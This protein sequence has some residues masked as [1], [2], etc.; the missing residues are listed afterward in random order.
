MLAKLLRYCESKLSSEA[1]KDLRWYDAG[2]PKR[3]SVQSFFHAYARALLV[4]GI[5]AT[6][7]DTW[8]KNHRFFEIFTLENCK[9]RTATALLRA[10]G[11][12][13]NNVRGSKLTAIHALGHE[14]ASLTPRQAAD[15]YFSGTLLSSELGERHVPEL[16]KLRFVAPTNARF[17]LLNMGAEELL[18]CDTWLTAFMHYFRCDVQALKQAGRK[19][20]WKLGRVDRVLWWYCKQEIRSSKNLPAHFRKLGFV[21]ITGPSPRKR[22]MGTSNC[23]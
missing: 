4:S 19:L 16:D 10:V 1:K 21:P 20:G 8:A 5:G 6:A 18:K 2:R 7:A 14:L 23:Q 15:R 9:R 11:Q 22:A 17:I 12:E 3:V 13:P